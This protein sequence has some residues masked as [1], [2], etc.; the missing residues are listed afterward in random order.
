MTISD[1]EVRHVDIDVEAAY[2]AAQGML[3]P[4]PCMSHTSRQVREAMQSVQL[5]HD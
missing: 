4:P 5:Q 2:V 1:V 3:E